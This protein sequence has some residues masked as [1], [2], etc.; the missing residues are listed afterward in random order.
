MT[1]YFKTFENFKNEKKDTD[2]HIFCDMDGVLTNFEKRFKELDSNTENLSPSEYDAKHGKWSIW[3]LIDDGVKWWSDMEWMP[4][5][6]KLW[7]WLMP[8]KVTILSAPSKQQTSRDGKLIWL[9][10]NLHIK[11]NFYT[12]NPRKWKPHYKIIFNKDKWKFARSK[13]DILIDDTKS[14]VDAWRAAGGT[15]IHHIS[16]SKTIRELKDIMY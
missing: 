6:Q 5:G 2:F 14:K 15:A 9:K 3:D 11:Q 12:V 13:N 8:Y 7:Q 10:R 4:D 1:D 16:A